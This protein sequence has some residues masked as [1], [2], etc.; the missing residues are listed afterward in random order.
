[1]VITSG[2]ILAA[3]ASALDRGVIVHGIY[4]GPEMASA[5]RQ[6]K[7]P[8]K[9]A[10][11]KNIMDALVAKHSTPYDPK[12][13]NGLHDFMHDKLLVAGPTVAT[14]SFNFSESAEHNA[15]DVLFI[16]DPQLAH[17]YAAY[18]EALVARWGTGRP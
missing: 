7:D 1:M 2:T 8:T 16:R 6:M 15:E 4:D 13:P 5:L 17:D 3:V 14:G 9:I 10:L 12:H 18:V 11:M